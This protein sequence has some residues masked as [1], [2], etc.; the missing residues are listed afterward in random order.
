LRGE[1]EEDWADGSRRTLLVYVMQA[2]DFK[3]QL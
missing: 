2:S 3:E 1:V